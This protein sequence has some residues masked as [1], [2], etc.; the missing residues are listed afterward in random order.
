MTAKA[1]N[2]NNSFRATKALKYA[3][4]PGILPRIKELGGSGFGYLAFLI[5]RVYLAVRILPVN[6]PFTNPANIGEFGIRQVVAEA[7]NH[8]KLGWGNI[9]QIVIFLAILAGI[10]ILALQFVALLLILVSGQAWAQTVS[11]SGFEGIF[12]TQNPENDIAFLLL[13]HVFGIPDFFGSRVLEN[14]Q[15]PFHIAL[16]ALFQFYNLAIL[17]VAVLIFLYY[18]LVVVAETAQS[19][20][21]FGKRFNKIYAPLRLVAALGLL[22]PLNYGLN[23]S[24]YITLF[25]AKMGSGLATN[26]WVIFN[27]GLDNPMG[28]E[29][30]SLIAEPL[31]PDS[32]GLVSFMSV[33]QACRYA[34]CMMEEGG[35]G[36]V[37]EGDG[38]PIEAYVKMGEDDPIPLPDAGAD[39]ARYE[40]LIEQI[41]GGSLKI[42]FGTDAN[43]NSPHPENIIPYCGEINIPGNV[44]ELESLNLTEEGAPKQLQADYFRIVAFLWGKEDLKKLGK[45]VAYAQ[46]R[47]EDT[48][49]CSVT[50][51][52]QP[53]P[54]NPFDRSADMTISGDS[55]TNNNYMPPSIF[56]NASSASTKTF[57]ER[58][59]SIFINAA[60]ENVDLSIKEEVLERGW[61]G[62]GIWYNNI[63]HLNGALITTANNIPHASEYPMVMEKVLEE[64]NQMDGNVPD[65]KK[66]SPNVADNTDISLDSSADLYYA[67]VMDEVF[68]YWHCE[69]TTDDFELTGN[70]FWDVANALFGTQGLFDI[71]RNSADEIHPLAQLTAI[72]KGLVD[73]A[74]TNLTHA[75]A[76][77]IGGGAGAILGPHIGGM[78]QAASGF[79]VTTATIGLTVGF[80]LYYVLPFLP[81][82]YFFF[83]VGAWVKTIFEAMVGAPLWALAHLRIDGDGFS[84][85]SASNGYFLIFEIFLRPVLTVFGLIGSMAIFTAM[86][87]ILNEV[88]D[89]VV[90]NATGAEID[91]D[92]TSLTPDQ[93]SLDRGVVDEFFYTIVYAV[94]MYMMAISSFKMIDLVPSNILRWLGSNV[95]SFVDS[96]KQDPTQGL[97]QYAAIGGVTIGSQLF[98]GVSKLGEGVGNIPGLAKNLGGGATK[99]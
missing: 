68:Q 74:T 27:R 87:V 91:P 60:R 54:N 84:G 6:H 5:A 35:G 76:F 82:I 33:V 98:Q 50:Y 30:A 41:D 45:R 79:F 99:S 62:A 7:A 88:F 58:D 29:N 59:I 4:L 21:P 69:I 78:F 72:G 77:S 48:D 67:E 64:R 81:F 26:G 19:G 80:I 39:K 8:V 85:Q 1:D 16:Q 42:I 25:S 20:S 95:A 94:I 75:F 13:D 14:G 86:T 93:I 44:A 49:P 28:V 43:S 96:G 57:I 23:A 66:F 32:M 17:I 71:R 11:A 40:S 2:S 12:N 22:V 89:L 61:G 47:N 70:I 18:V 38:I 90:L 37:C 97:T 83:A 15:E 31:P 36:G 56:K 52:P 46:D 24:Q 92:N 51:T 10:V 34:Y 63:A 53:E 55:C 3:L 65:C 9:D 73:S